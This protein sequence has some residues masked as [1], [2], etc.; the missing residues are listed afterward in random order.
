MHHLQSRLLEQ[1]PQIIH[2]FTTRHGG[3]SHSPYASNNIAF[4][5]GDDKKDVLANHQKLAH[6]LGYDPG[7][8]I[9]MRQIHSDRVTIVDDSFDFNIPPECDALVTDAPNL[10]LM[11]MVAD[12]TPILVYDP[13]RQVIAAIHAGRAGAFKNIISKTVAVMEES[14]QSNPADLVAV[15]GPSIGVCCYEVGDIIYEEAKGMNLVYAVKK[16]ERKYYLD[17]KQILN[18]QLLQAGL[19]AEHIEDIEQCSACEHD[20]FFSYRADRQKTGRMAGLI[21]LR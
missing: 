11:V 19:S 14:F 21:M 12:C 3:Q 17:V 9:H 4:H 20:T 6:D 1:F 18:R 5:V 16:E 10:P 2:T 8:L 15:L 7:R 13:N